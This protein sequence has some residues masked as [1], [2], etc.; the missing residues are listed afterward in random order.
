LGNGFGCSEK[1]KN[2]FGEN[3]KGFYL[4]SPKRNGGLKKGS[5]SGVRDASR[6]LKR[7][8]FSLFLRG[9]IYS[10]S[11]SRGDESSLREKIM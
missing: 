3:K 7:D 11:V 8:G 4:C 9:E 5:G 1:N 10:R 6:G 2:K